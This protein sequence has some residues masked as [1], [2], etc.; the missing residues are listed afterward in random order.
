LQHLELPGALA[1]RDAYGRRLKWIGLSYDTMEE[2]DMLVF[3]LFRD[4]VDKVL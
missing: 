3:E 2:R 4:L 1:E